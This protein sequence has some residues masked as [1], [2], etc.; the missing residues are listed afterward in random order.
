MD[1]IAFLLF[2][3]AAYTLAGAAFR[4]IRPFMHRRYGWTGRMPTTSALLAWSSLAASLG[5]WRVISNVWPN[6]FWLPVPLVVFAAIATI[7]F[8]FRTEPTWPKANQTKA[9]NRARR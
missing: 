7:V 4:S 3:A 9:R 1:G 8:G 6:A 5:G 2:V